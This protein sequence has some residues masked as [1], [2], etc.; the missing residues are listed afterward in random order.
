M[1]SYIATLRSCCIAHKHRAVEPIMNELNSDYSLG[2]LGCTF[3]HCFYLFEHVVLVLV[4][5]AT[6]FPVTKLFFTC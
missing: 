2:S 6:R 4:C 1:C 3:K 5:I